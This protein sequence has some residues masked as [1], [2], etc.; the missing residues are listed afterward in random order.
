[1]PWNDVKRDRKKKKKEKEDRLLCSLSDWAQKIRTSQPETHFLVGFPS[2]VPSMLMHQQICKF[3]AWQPLMVRCI[4]I[5]GNMYYGTIYGSC[6]NWIEWISCANWLRQHNGAFCRRNNDIPT[7]DKGVYKSYWP[8]HVTRSSELQ[9]RPVLYCSTHIQLE[10]TGISG[11][12]GIAIYELIGQQSVRGFH[13]IPLDSKDSIGFQG[14]H[15]IPRIPLD[16]KDSIGFHWIP[17]IPLD[18]KDSHI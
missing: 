18:S 8:P 7:T 16:S 15:W 14:F 13:W 2:F 3:D 11:I 1:M 17:R 6:P 12:S 9:A 5:Y 4:V 10:S